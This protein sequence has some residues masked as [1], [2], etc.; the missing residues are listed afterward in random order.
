MAGA[1]KLTKMPNKAIAT[2]ASSKVK[3]CCWALPWDGVGSSIGNGMFLQNVVA[4]GSEGRGLK[5]YKMNTKSH[6]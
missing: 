3:P 4:D 5:L 2:K 6:N 1:A